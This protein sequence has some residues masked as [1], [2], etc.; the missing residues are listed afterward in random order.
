MAQDHPGARPAHHPVRRRSLPLQQGAAGCLPALRPTASFTFIGA[1]HG[2]PVVRGQLRAA[3]AGPRVCAAVADR[4]GTDAADR[5]AW[6]ELNDRH[7]PTAAAIAFRRQTRAS[8]WPR[9]ADGDARRPDQRGR[10]GG[11][12]RRARPNATSV[13]AEWLETSLSLNRRRF[14]KGGDAFYDQISALHKSVRRLGPGRGAVL[15]LPHDRRR[16]RSQLSVARLVPHGDRRHRAGRSARHGN[17]AAERRRHLRAPR[18]RP[19]ASWRWRRA[20]VYLACAAKSNARL[21]QP[22]TPAAASSEEHGSAP[23]CPCTC[24]SADKR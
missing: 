7:F 10:S 18:V 15:V 2:K 6:L 16:R 9:W 23:T 11:R 8:S 22:T 4:R 21:Q 12:N 3:V 1:D 19:R 5:R 20:V 14:D 13:D 24:A 17:L